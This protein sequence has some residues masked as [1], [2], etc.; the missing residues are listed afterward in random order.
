MLLR[1]MISPGFWIR[2]W[3]VRLTWH[4][5]R[6]GLTKISIPNLASIKVKH[7]HSTHLFSSYKA[8]TR[9]ET[10]P[11]IPSIPMEVCAAVMLTMRDKCHHVEDPMHGMNN[12]ITSRD[13]SLF[14]ND[15]YTAAFGVI[16]AHLVRGPKICSM[17]ETT[18]PRGRYLLR[19]IKAVVMVNRL[20]QRTCSVGSVDM[21]SI[22]QNATH[23]RIRHWQRGLY[24][25]EHT[26]TGYLNI[27][28]DEPSSYI[29]LLSSGEVWLRCS[30]CHICSAR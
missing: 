17:M 4:K 16:S 2:R 29:I 9:S 27:L 5:D 26:T 18:Y 11:A 22:P 8:Y 30:T 15:W 19:T 12:H 3:S 10:R 24:I 1:N 13:I 23:R 14:K 20:D 21:K 25:V 6:K 7:I 28:I